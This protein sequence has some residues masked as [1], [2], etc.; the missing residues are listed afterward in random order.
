[1]A[2]GATRILAQTPYMTTATSPCWITRQ[3]LTFSCSGELLLVM[4][5]A[6]PQVR[7]LLD[8]EG[9]KQW[10]P[11]RTSGY[12]ILAAAVDRSGVID[13]SEQYDG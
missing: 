8:L 5:Y 9:L 7:R 12:E 2:S 10:L 11:G 6:D 3:V 1:M 13:A 4:S